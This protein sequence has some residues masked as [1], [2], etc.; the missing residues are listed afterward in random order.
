MDF[1]MMKEFMDRLCAWRIP[2]NTIVV[3]HKNKEVFRYSSGYSNMEQQIP[4]NGEELLHIYSCSK[5]STVVAALQLYEKGLFLLDDP[6]SNFIPEFREMYIKGTDGNLRKATKPITMRHLFTHTAGLTYDINSN[7]LQALRVAT[8]GRM[9]TVEVARAIAKEPLLFEPGERW[10]YSLSHDVLAAVVEVISGKRFSAYAKENLFAP[11]GI[12]DVHYHA[13]DIIKKRM[14]EQYRFATNDEKENDLVKLQISSTEQEGFV[15]NQGKSNDLVLGEDYDSGGAGV[16]ISVPSY[17]KFAN[18]LAMGGRGANGERILS[19][20]TVDLLR[21][22]QLSATQS[23][24]SYHW[25][26]LIGYGYGLGVR[27]VI[28]R[29]QS[30]FNGSVGE[31]GWGGAAGATILVDPDNEFSYFYA[32]HMLNPQ[33]GYYQPRLRNVAYTCLLQ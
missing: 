21:T 27:T 5:V 30:G 6:V 18:A 8:G 7:S 19:R 12:T 20:G 28:D 2:G 15:V 29:A 10:S 32:H 9:P 31:F 14:A 26:N 24:G 17:A 11:L 4:M 3:Y 16:I 1:S 13:D 33:E 22:N 23:E 25:S